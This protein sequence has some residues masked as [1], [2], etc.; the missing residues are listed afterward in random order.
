MAVQYQIRLE[1]EWIPRELNVRADML[2]RVVD[3][4]DWCLNPAVFRW[5]DS[6]W[7]PHTV[8]R[9][10]DH[11]NCQVTRF[12]SRCWC[13]GSE[14]VDAFT[15]NWSTENN[16]W[17]PPVALVPRVISHARVC[18]A[19]G[20]LIVPE[21]PASPFRLACFESCS[22]AVCYFYGPCGGLC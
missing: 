7:G 22:W 11:N 1:P 21:W 3:H 6:L 5:L 4:D 10:A 9:F 14:A 13:P 8:D 18:G 12:N 16:W 20:T 19:S 2:S 15:V 17:C